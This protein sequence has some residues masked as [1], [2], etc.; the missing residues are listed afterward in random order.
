MLIGKLINP[1]IFYDKD[2]TPI[3]F[4]QTFIIEDENGDQI[5]RYEVHFDYNIPDLE[6]GD[7][8]REKVREKEAEFSLPETVQEIIRWDWPEG[9]E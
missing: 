4:E 7:W 2:R 6:I 8:V 1:F 9:I 3:E 5:E